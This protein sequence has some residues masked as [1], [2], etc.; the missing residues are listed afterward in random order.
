MSSHNI[1]SK[2]KRYLK[3]LVFDKNNGICH[4]CERLIDSVEKMTMNHI[5]PYNESRDNNISNLMPAHILC[6]SLRADYPIDDKIKTLIKKLT[7]E[8][9]LNLQTLKEH[10]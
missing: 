7:H 6:N 3:P 4:I 5:I 1:S 9:D 2:Q 8:Q 10:V